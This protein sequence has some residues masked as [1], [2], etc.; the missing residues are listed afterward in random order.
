MYHG[1]VVSEKGEALELNSPNRGRS[2]AWG[3]AESA[4]IRLK[5]SG[6]PTNLSHRH[7]QVQAKSPE[8][9]RRGM[10]PGWA[11]Q[12]RLRSR[13]LSFVQGTAAELP[14]VRSTY[15]RPS[16]PRSLQRGAGRVQNAPV[17]E[18]AQ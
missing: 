7:R 18:M 6:Q 8:D 2:L 9:S 15:Q 1:K 4:L 3:D 13:H 5:L 16:P 10:T 17:A 11:C 12:G 14:L